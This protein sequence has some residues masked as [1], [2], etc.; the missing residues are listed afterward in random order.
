[1]G[2]QRTSDQSQSTLTRQWRELPYSTGLLFY[3][4]LF[5]AAIYKLARTSKDECSDSQVHTQ[6]PR[7]AAVNSGFQFHPMN[8]YHGLLTSRL[9]PR[10]VTAIYTGPVAQRC[11]WLSRR[12]LV[13]AL[14]LLHEI[15]TCQRPD[16]SGVQPLSL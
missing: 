9:T 13:A 2:W 5:I 16:M 3:V 6:C 11:P 1:M 15:L 14:S 12:A 8:L 7:A 10:H 4:C